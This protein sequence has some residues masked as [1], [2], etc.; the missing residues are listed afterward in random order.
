M[1]AT[2]RDRLQAALGAEVGLERE[3]GGAGMS[4]VFVGIEHALGRRI[5]VKVLPA[6]LMAGGNIER[7]RREILLAANLQHP[8]IVPLLT[9]AERDGLLFFTMPFVQ[10][11][12]LR[13]RLKRTGALSENAAVRI[14]RDVAEA[15]AYAHA[16]GVIHRDI[17]P[18]NILLA[19]DSALIADFGV[20]KALSAA[21]RAGVSRTSVTATNA[22]VGTPLYMAPEQWAG[23]PSIDHRADIYAL[24]LVAYEMLV[25][26]SP[27][28]D[29]APHQMLAS[30]LMEAPAPLSYHLPDLSPVLQSLIMRC[31]EKNASARPDTA[32]VVLNELEGFVSS[33]SNV[34]TP[35]PATHP[36]HSAGTGPAYHSTP[37][38]GA[39]QTTGNSIAVLPFV[40]L[41]ADPENEY[42]SDG[43]TEEIINALA[44]VN[45]LRVAARTSS[46]A[47]KGTKQDARTIGNRLNVNTILEG[48]VRRIGQ[49]IRVTAQL[50][51]VA[52]GYYLWS[53]SFAREIQD[54]FAIEEEIARSIASALIPKLIS[55][56]ISGPS[57]RRVENLQAYELYLKG[58]YH[59]NQ[60]SGDRLKTGLTFFQQAIALEPSFAQA[61]AGVG[62]S[63]AMLGQYG[64]L[65]PM[66][67]FP[68]AK[69]AALQALSLDDR[70]AEAHA[71]LGFVLF[72][73]DWDYA[74]AER[75]FKR[76]LEFNPSY[77]AAYQWYG[78]LLAVLGRAD[79]AVAASGRA[80]KL[81]PL[82]P[83]AHTNLANTL[84]STRRF[85]ETVVQCEKTI[86]LEPRFFLAYFF[87][88]P[89][90]I[91]QGRML[92]AEQAA[93]RCAELAPESPLALFALGYVCARAGL[94]AEAQRTMDDLADR[95][96]RGVGE[97]F[98]IG[99]IAA[100]MGEL[101]SAF[102]WS[103]R[104]VAQ[105]SDKLVY[106]TAPAADP[107]RGDP[108]FE[109][110]L[111]RTN[112]AT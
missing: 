11:E 110:L 23:D 59:W 61:Y 8:H 57:V 47:F 48:S 84:Y 100:A 42:F 74:A 67:A 108:R 51:N 91:Q 13:A 39:G 69:A 101:D 33:G 17:K 111:K 29:R 21:T 80:V 97:A 58:R 92:E 30:H 76:A 109:S 104:A 56:S 71:S 22:M 93:R 18:E 19:G 12:S 70:L 26:R 65:Q 28:A 68:K 24:G 53:E 102:E 77:V 103:E 78:Q 89:C 2:L 38:S 96:K 40:N 83:V 14:I 105:R 5:V 82:S 64:F 25:G 81:D 36:S 95:W 52:D 72:F 32:E 87:L 112:L 94:R 15:M 107:M 16:H 85:D 31:L 60:R 106:L 20:A 10:G 3:L 86:E 43:M 54:V 46:F 99:L 4:R 75:E 34:A 62:D 73:H 66:Q 45:T 88:A 6:E 1:I 9:A 98:F 27:F 41:S 35:T 90:L 49:R 37:V 7:F 44:K 50:I 63:Y 55:D 79:Q